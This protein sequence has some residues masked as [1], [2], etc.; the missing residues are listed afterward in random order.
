M[1]DYELKIVLLGDENTGKSKFYR[2]IIINKII[3]SGQYVPTIAT[4]FM[5]KIIHFKNKI[6]KINLWDTTG[7]EQFNNLLTL[8]ARGSDV[9]LLFYNSLNRKSFK[10]VDKI[11]K[12]MKENNPKKNAIYIL[13]ESKY[14]LKIESN[15]DKSIV[16][17][18]EAL[19][20]ADKNNLLF[21]HLSNKEK[22]KKEI[23]EIIVKILNQYL[24]KKL[25]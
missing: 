2:N 21:C 4:C 12:K 24:N 15:I 14:D 23:D 13:I 6:F 19:E 20:Y 25:Y 11:L 7:Q 17:E 22:Y 16:T 1:I 3:D 10:R 18:E 9:Y 8:Y 5:I